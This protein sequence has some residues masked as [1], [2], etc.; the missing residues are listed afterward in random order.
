MKKIL[1]LLAMLFLV[2]ASGRAE[3]PLNAAEAPWLWVY[4]PTNFLVPDAEVIDWNDMFDPYHNAVDKYYLVGSTL[5]KSWDGLDKSMIIANWSSGKAAESLK[6]FAARGNRQV[7]AGYYDAD[8]VKAEV[9]HWSDAAHSV[10]GVR[11]FMY[12]T[13]RNDYKNLEK[14]AEAVRGR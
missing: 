9:A 4:A 2:A 3:S 1:P 11:G 8:D 5:E 12:T 14:Y 7:I 13:W 6:F 10:A